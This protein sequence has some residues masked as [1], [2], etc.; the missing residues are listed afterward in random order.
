MIKGLRV[1]GLITKEQI[2][3]A[4]S[5][6]DTEARKIIKGNAEKPK[7]PDGMFILGRRRTLRKHEGR[8]Y[9]KVDGRMILLTD[10]LVMDRPKPE[11]E[12]NTKRKPRKK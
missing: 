6:I 10:A 7:A 1:R 5:A 4:R 9:V 8:T 3:R 12:I 11:S 2:P